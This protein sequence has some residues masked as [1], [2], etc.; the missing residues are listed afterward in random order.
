MAEFFSQSGSERFAASSV[1]G[2]SG[3]PVRVFNATWLSSSVAGVFK[4]YDG[5]STGGDLWVGEIGTA[6]GSKTTNWET[7]ILFNSGCFYEQAAN[8]TASILTFRTEA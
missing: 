7:G 8:V 2:R 4:L 3:K 5:T 6:N 1:V